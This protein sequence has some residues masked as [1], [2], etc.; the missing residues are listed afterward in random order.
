[1]P[2]PSIRDVWTLDPTVTFLNH[3]S[4]GACPRPCSTRR[5]RLRARI[6]REPGA[7]SSSATSRAASTPRAPRSARSSARTPTTS[8]FV[9]NA[10]TGVNAVAALARASA[11][12]TSS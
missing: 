1:M 7:R 6:E 2:S 10:T 12:A 4:F 5:Q 11:P 3:G 9:P 8:A